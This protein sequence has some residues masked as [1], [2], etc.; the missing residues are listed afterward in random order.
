MNV[1]SLADLIVEEK[2]LGS[3]IHCTAETDVFAFATTL[4]LAAHQKNEGIHSLC[5]KLLRPRC[6]PTLKKALEHAL[7]SPE[8]FV[9]LHARFVNLPLPLVPVL[10]SSSEEDRAW[11][12]SNDVRGG[13]EVSLLVEMGVRGASSCPPR[14]SRLSAHIFRYTV[15]GNVP[16][17]QEPDHPKPLLSGSGTWK[18]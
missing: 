12:Q 13:D 7:G 10:H 18:Q 6:P 2:G 4:S 17:Y 5:D 16:S 8:T 15:T 11:A 3:I 14:P 1:T 9:F